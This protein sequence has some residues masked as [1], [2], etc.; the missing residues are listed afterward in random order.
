MD[1]LRYWVR[2]C[3]STGSA[4]TWHRPWRAS[5]TTSTGSALLRHHPPGPGAVAGQAHRRA[6][7]RLARRLPGGQ[8]PGRLGGMERPLPRYGA[9]FWRRRRAGWPSW[10][11]ADRLVG[12]VGPGRGRRTRAST[13]SPPT[14][15]SRCTTWSA[16]TTS[17][18]RRTARTTAT[19]T[20]QRLA[21][22]AASRAR[23]TTRIVRLRERRSATAGRCCCRRACRCSAAATRSAARSAAT[24]TPTARTTR[25]AGSTGKLDHAQGAARLHPAA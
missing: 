10:L 8:L 6:L 16:T 7:G 4:S 18:T 11:S 22:T 9:R 21:G 13:S 24:T 5:C 15:A 19:V 25:S 12:P 3:T 1:S 14:T 23:P 2:R 20:P 17:T